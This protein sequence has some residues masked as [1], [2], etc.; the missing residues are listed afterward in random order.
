MSI[1]LA[2]RVRETTN[3]TGAGT[4]NLLGAAVGFQ[5]F[6]GGAGD[7][8]IVYYCIIGQAGGDAEGE[9]E[10]GIGTVTAAA[11]D[12]LSRDTV[13]DSSNGGAAV[14]FSADTKDVFLTVPAEGIVAGLEVQEPS[15][16]ATLDFDISGYEWVQFSGWLQP[17]ND[18]VDMLMRFSNDGGA[19]FREAVTDYDSMIQYGYAAGDA[20]AVIGETGVTGI[21]LGQNVGNGA[22]EGWAGDFKVINPN[23]ANW[24]THLLGEVGEVDLGGNQFYAH[25]GGRVRSAKE[26]NNAI[27]FL[28]SAGNIAD[29]RVAMHGLKLQT[30]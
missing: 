25:G 10:T 23:D 20:T 21:K 29:G 17:A 1:V 15:A 9:W 22:S 24:F 8:A 4:V 30:L 18:G 7:G 13:L 2:D 27:R 12:T 28:F 3:T 6:V 11:P 5:T 26:V 14:N 16:V 19:S